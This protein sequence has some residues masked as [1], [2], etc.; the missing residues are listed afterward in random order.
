LIR[1]FDAQC[2]TNADEMAELAPLELE[3]SESAAATQG[4]ASGSERDEVPGRSPHHEHTRVLDAL[5]PRSARSVDDVASRAGL[6]IAEVQ[7]VLG[8]LELDGAVQE[9][10]TGWVK[11]RASA[12][13]TGAGAV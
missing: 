11:Q 7:S 6:S 5:A 13:P 8:V 3:G 2:V 9:R 1:D 4:S 10:A 12:L